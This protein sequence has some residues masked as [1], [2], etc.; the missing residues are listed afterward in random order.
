MIT[1]CGSLLVRTGHG[2]PV[3]ADADAARRRLEMIRNL[4]LLGE[5]D[6]VAPHLHKL[7]PVAEALD[8]ARIIAALDNGEFRA[9]IE[10]IDGYLRKATALVVAGFT[11]I[12]R[13]RFV[14]ESLELRL[15]SLTDEK[16]EIE[17]SLITFN[18]GHDDELGSLIQRILKARA[19]LARLLY[20]SNT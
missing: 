5:Q 6:E 10:H 1:A 2:A 3:V 11:D 20:E 14:L 4:I 15:E 17:R 19:E 8:L 18:R 13:L 16:A 9:A 12:P 7:R